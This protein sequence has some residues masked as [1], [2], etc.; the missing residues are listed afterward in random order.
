MVIE[1]GS[2][3]GLQESPCLEKNLSQKKTVTDQH[4]SCSGEGV[5]LLWVL[6]RHPPLGVV[7]ADLMRTVAGRDPVRMALVRQRRLCL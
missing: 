6:P 4:Y 1:T 2:K 3:V 7:G 5:A